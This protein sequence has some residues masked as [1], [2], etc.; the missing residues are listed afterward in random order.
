MRRHRAPPSLR[1]SRKV[2]LR[3]GGTDAAAY[4]VLAATS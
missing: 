3:L 1:S 4:D 2:V